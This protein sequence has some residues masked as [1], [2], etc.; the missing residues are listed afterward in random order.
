MDVLGGFD[1]EPADEA[2]SAS[3]QRAA[4]NSDLTVVKRQ[5]QQYGTAKERDEISLMEAKAEME[6]LK[7]RILELQVCQPEHMQ[8]SDFAM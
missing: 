7:K 3:P 5:M 6:V 1:G 2:K 4:V 8:H